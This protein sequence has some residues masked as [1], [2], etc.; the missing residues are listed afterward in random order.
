MDQDVRY[1]LLNVY[2]LTFNMFTSPLW[3]AM[4]FNYGRHRLRHICMALKNRPPF[5]AFFVFGAQAGIA[6]DTAPAAN[7]GFLLARQNFP[8]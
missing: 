3:S 5:G 7:W 8:G 4:F 2:F 1:D 6:A